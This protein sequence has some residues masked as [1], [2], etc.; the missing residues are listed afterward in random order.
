MRLLSQDYLMIVKIH[1]RTFRKPF[2]AFY[3]FKQNVI[4]IL[5]IKERNNEI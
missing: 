4:L 1:M 5:K 2:E 3:C